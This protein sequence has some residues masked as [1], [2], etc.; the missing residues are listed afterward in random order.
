VLR[1]PDLEP[2]L[3]RGRLGQ[4][5]ARDLRVAEDDLRDGGVVGARGEP[6]PRRRLRRLPLGAGRDDLAARARLVLALVGE[7]HPSRHVAGGVQ[8]APLDALH[9]QRVVGRER[10]AGLQT[11]A[12]EPEVVRAR[13]ASRR[14]Q[15][16]VPPELL[17]GGGDDD[18]PVRLAP[19]GGDLGARA[20]LDAAV[21]QG[22]RD[23][24]RRLRLVR[25]EQRRTVLQQHDLRAERRP[26]RRHLDADDAPA[27]HEQPARRPRRARRLAAGPRP[28]VGEALDGRERGALPVQTTT[29]CRAR[30]RAVEPSLPVTSTS[31]TPA[32]RPEPRA[33]GTPMPSSQPSWPSSRHPEVKPSRRRS[34]AAASS[35]PV[36]AWREPSTARA[37]ASASTGRSRALLGM[38][39]Q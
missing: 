15:Q 1:R 16:L 35:S 27:E 19:G 6:A 5:D 22:L 37:A 24:D 13:P 25:R 18:G 32:S 36:T 21:A 30:R 2:A 17:A 20:H 4:P 34:T 29:A 9:E 3:A 39:A 7:Q 38:H 12:L 14:H 8:P 33:S 10:R 28:D 11:D 26:G 23:E 31:R